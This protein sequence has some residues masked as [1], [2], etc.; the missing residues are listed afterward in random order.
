M[1]IGIATNCSEITYKLLKKIATNCSKV[2]LE[3]TEPP[4]DGFMEQELNVF[5]EVVGLGQSAPLANF[6][7]MLRLMWI[8]S[9]QYAESSEM[10]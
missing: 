5:Q 7:P 1:D 8:D 2:Y 6:L 10:R 9:L 3:F 4:N